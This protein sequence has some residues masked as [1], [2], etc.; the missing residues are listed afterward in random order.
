MTLLAEQ[1]N[2]LSEIAADDDAPPSSIGMGIY[3]N[4]FRARLI[5]AL[6]SGYERTRRWVGDDAFE[7]AAAHY[8]LTQPP[9]SW[10]LD[11]FGAQF[12]ALLAELFAGD[13]EVAELAWLEWHMQ[14]AFAA[15]DLPELDAARLGNAGLAE[16]D[17]ENLRFTMA[18]GFVTRAV[19]HD[20]SGLWVAL[21][22]AE[23]VKP[24]NPPHAD[25]HLIVWRRALRPHFRL[26]EPAEFSALDHLIKGATLGQSGA[27][28]E[29]AGRDPE[30]LGGW[31]AG[32]FSEGLFA[33]YTVSV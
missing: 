14:Q 27:A 33:D 32:W 8:I 17:W 29:H 18:A 20:L 16:R 22:P 19:S 3:R 30:Q 6:E 2:F 15:P 9:S 31:L 26:L 10:T 1:T 5:G 24:E 28:L 25:N 12:P 7:A 4:A 23:T 13:P 21:T 11:A